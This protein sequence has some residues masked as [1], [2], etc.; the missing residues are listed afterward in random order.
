M[1]NDERFQRVGSVTL[2]DAP[3]GYGRWFFSGGRFGGCQLGGEMRAFLR[4]SADLWRIHHWDITDWIL[5][6]ALWV[7]ILLA[8]TAGFSVLESLAK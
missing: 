1:T 3:L 6:G 2:E 8:V 5:I 4:R 7:I